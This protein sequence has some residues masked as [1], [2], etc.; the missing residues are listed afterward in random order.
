[1]PNNDVRPSFQVLTPEQINRVHEIVLKILETDGV[2]VDDENAKKIIEKAGGRP[3]EN[4]RVQIP[5]ELVNWA[6]KTA[7]S[8]IKMY[9]REGAYAFELNGDGSQ[10]AVFGVGVTNLFYQNPENDDVIPFERKHM[11]IATRL[12]NTLDHYDTVATT[13]AIRDLPPEVA[14]I[15]GALEMIANTRKTLILLIND[16]NDFKNVLDLYEHLHGNLAEKPFII[17]YFNLSRLNLFL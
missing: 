14:D 17:P 12:G 16:P 7:P 8:E 4:N 3:V 6:I 1:M 5:E 9:D 10:D 11:A 13:G 2:R 15:Y